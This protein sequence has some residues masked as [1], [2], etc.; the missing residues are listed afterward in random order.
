MSRKG[1]PEDAEEL[2][3]RVQALGQLSW[4]ALVLEYVDACRKVV[5][6]DPKNDHSGGLYA[7]EFV[8]AMRW[9]IIVGLVLNDAE[10][11][12]PSREDA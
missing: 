9:A 5:E 7:R 1:E 8:L 3:P 12:R 4:P 2:G 10:P 11:D 6:L